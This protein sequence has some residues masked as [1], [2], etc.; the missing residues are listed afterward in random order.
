MSVYFYVCTHI[1]PHTWWSLRDGSL[2]GIRRVVLGGLA[3][4]VFPGWQ[5]AQQGGLWVSYT[6]GPA[7]WQWSEVPASPSQGMSRRLLVDSGICHLEP[8][9]TRYLPEALWSPVSHLPFLNF[10]PQRTLQR[11]L[12]PAQSRKNSEQCT[13]LAHLPWSHGDIVPW[14]MALTPLGRTILG[15]M[16]GSTPLLDSRS[17]IHPRVYTPSRL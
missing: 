12:A 17:W 4:A 3:R 5:K 16:S 7:R 14:A 6:L 15:S 11:S 1:N 10:S 9:R 2:R 8:R 13:S